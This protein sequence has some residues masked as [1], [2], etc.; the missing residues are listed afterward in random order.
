MKIAILG[1]TS[2]IAQDLV[3]SFAEHSDDELVLYARRPDVV[4]Q[5]L[6]AV[7]LPQRYAVADF[8]AFHADLHF[9]ALL[10][11]V[12]VGNPAQAAA[13]GASILDVTQTYDQLALA[14]VRKHPTCRYLFLSSGAAYGDVFAQPADDDVMARVPINHLQ[15]QDWYGMDKL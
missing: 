1:A 14:Y 15:P 4:L 7:G 3:R 10:N 8:S 11:F 5:W 2:Q 9:D 12:G 6:A 13:M